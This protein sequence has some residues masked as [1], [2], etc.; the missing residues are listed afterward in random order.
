MSSSLPSLLLY[1]VD[2]DYRPDDPSALVG[3]LQQ[4]GLIGDALEELSGERYQAGHTFLQHISFLGCSPAVEFE[5][6]A[7]DSE[8]FCHAGI[9]YSEQLQFRGGPQQVQVHCRQCRHREEDWADIIDGWQADPQN[10]RYVCP[11]CGAESHATEL[12]WR[13]TGAFARAFIELY[14]I[15]PHEAV[16]TDGI[17]KRLRDATGVDW[18]YIYVR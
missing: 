9:R 15:Y 6:E 5:P 14:N 1:P 11:A 18:K 17:L 13:K 3:L 12:N 16:P 10:H 2:P 7:P 8:Q 4:A